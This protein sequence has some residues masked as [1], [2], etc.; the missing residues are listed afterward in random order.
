MPGYD[1]R[2]YRLPALALLCICASSGIAACG[3]DEPDLAAEQAAIT[4]VLVADETGGPERCEALYTDAYLDENWDENVTA[5]GGETP[6]EKCRNEPAGEG[7]TEADVK[8]TVES[9]E[10]DTATASARLRAHPPVT[11]TLIREDG[12]WKIDGFAE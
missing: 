6:L 12:A 9:V 8:V 3:S 7:I 11:Y 4:A 10:G 2:V 1:P 5:Y